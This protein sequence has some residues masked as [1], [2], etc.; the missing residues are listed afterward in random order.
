MMA[1]T[2]AINDTAQ[3]GSN[4]DNETVVPSVANDWGVEVVQSDPRLLDG[5][6]LLDPTTIHHF[7]IELEDTAVNSLNSDPRTYVAATLIGH[8]QRLQVGMRLKGNSTYRD[9]SGKPSFKI[10]FDYVNDDQVLYG[11]EN[12]NFHANVLDASMLH[13]HLAFYIYR[14]AGLAAARTGWATIEINGTDYGLYGLSEVQDQVFLDQ[15]WDDSSGSVFESGS[16]EGS[17]DFNDSGCDCFEQDHEGDG[18]TNEDLQALCNAANASDDWYHGIQEFIDWTP[19]LRT[20]A[21]DM[22]L[23]H[24]DN[25]GFNIN[26]YRIYHEPSQERWYFTSWS[27]DLAFGWNPWGGAYCG[28]YGTWPADHRQGMLLSRCWSDANCK[29]DL[30]NEMEEMISRFE[31][32][33]LVEEIQRVY[34]LIQTDAHSD[35]RHAYST[36]Q[37]DSEFACMESWVQTRP[38]A[39]RSFISSQR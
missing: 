29:S 28:E 2:S 33:G 20:M 32:M 23:A 8:R 39:I 30:L 37:F 25:Y 14:N 10:N 5:S 7:A 21:M 36:A 18:D 17:C 35:P 27:T 1:C 9:L 13:E 6:I 34:S 19:W 26:N 31:N 3:I 12:L 15:W 16:F 11:L 22:I 38:D 24:W 4:D